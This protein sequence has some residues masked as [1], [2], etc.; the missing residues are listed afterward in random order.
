MYRRIQLATAVSTALL[1]VAGGTAAGCTDDAGADPKVDAELAD[2]GDVAPEVS[3]PDTTP[4]APDTSEDTGP[5]LNCELGEVR[6]PAETLV[7][8]SD[9]SAHSDQP[10]LLWSEQLV[11][12]D[13]RALSPD[14]PPA[15]SRGMRHD[16]EWVDLLILPTKRAATEEFK[17]A[18]VT[19]KI[20][21]STGDVR[22]YTSGVE[23]RYDSPWQLQID[24]LPLPMLLPDIETTVLFGAAVGANSNTNP[25][26][27]PHINIDLRVSS[28]E[29]GTGLSRR[30][31]DHL[32]ADR[33][34]LVTDAVILPHGRGAAL[35]SGREVLGLSGDFF[36]ANELPRPVADWSVELEALW[37]D[38]PADTE[39]KWLK[40][41][42]PTDMVVL[43]RHEP[44]SGEPVS[45]RLFRIDP[46]GDHSLVFEADGITDEVLKVS[47][48]Y[49]IRTG[50]RDDSSPSSPTLVS[51]GQVQAS[52]DLDCRDLVQT[53]DEE[54][55][56][57][58][59]D[60]DTSTFE[61]I[62]FDNELNVV[63]TRELDAGYSHMRLALAGAGD[64]LVLTGLA[65]GDDDTPEGHLLLVRP[66]AVTT[67]ALPEPDGWQPGE[68]AVD[69]AYP[70]L[71]Q[72]G[73]VVVAW[74]EQVHGLQ[75]NIAGMAHT[76]YPRA[77]F[78]GNHNR[79]FVDP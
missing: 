30:P 39:L 46:C 56:C 60:V 23:V 68:E 41:P 61:L 20:D 77:H 54:F 45:D 13:D 19:P 76:T 63:D 73:V 35:W 36:D 16:R 70:V 64:T 34:P 25:V 71:T 66:D 62:Y 2:A 78:G 52:L 72:R 50:S 42:G 27:E 1:L 31:V 79:G 3:S 14:G 48:A 18:R 21:A 44:S 69:H 67:Y 8:A 6:Y 28:D 5:E 75:T 53:G 37:P 9:V 26:H 49:L 4:D 29:W 12:R 15:V 58:S 11:D 24:D 65:Q 57:L 22:G 59:P 38:V 10:N 47:D 74:G 33:W 55:A 43:A 32:Y 51:D 40:S 17:A 7:A